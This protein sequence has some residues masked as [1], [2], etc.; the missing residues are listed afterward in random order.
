MTL[1]FSTELNGKPTYFVE[2]IISGLHMFNDFH[3]PLSDKYSHDL[4]MIETC[5]PKV[6]TIREDKSNRWKPGI[7]IHFVIN[8][9]TDKR[10][11]FVDTFPVISTQDIWIMPANKSVLVWQKDN[12]DSSNSY[13]DGYWKTLTQSQIE[14]LSRNDGFDTVQDFWNYFNREFGGKI[15]HWTGLLY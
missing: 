8:N 6:H 10:F 7:K 14:F 5:E 15:I 12:N 11:Q 9:R 4:D 13:R 2:K 3:F 1:S